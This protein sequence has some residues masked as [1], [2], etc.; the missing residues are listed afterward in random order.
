MTS[1]TPG[2]RPIAQAVVG[3]GLDDAMLTGCAGV[4]EF[5]IGGPDGRGGVASWPEMPGCFASERAP[6]HLSGGQAE[7]KQP[8]WTIRP[9]FWTRSR[10]LFPNVGFA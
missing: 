6:A 8:I 4:S 10:S 1:S 5:R 2:T 9:G 7:R 3:G